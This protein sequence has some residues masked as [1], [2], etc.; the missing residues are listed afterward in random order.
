MRRGLMATPDDIDTD[1]TL[2]IDGRN[3]PPGK[4]LRGVRAFF[5]VLDEVT[6]AVCGD[7]ALPEWAVQVKSGSN[8]VGVRPIG[9]AI[10]PTVIDL[11]LTRHRL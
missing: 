10:D 9:L 8:L 7:S 1:L 5:G 4:F 3:V 6:N 2:E 11:I